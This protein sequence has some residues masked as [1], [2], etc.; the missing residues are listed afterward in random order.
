MRVFQVCADPG[1]APDGT[2]GASVHLRSIATGLRRLGHEVTT[3]TRRPAAD[4]RGEPGLRRLCG[5][6][7]LLAEAAAVGAPDL[8]YERYS[9]GHR[10]GLA[11]ARALGRAFVLEVNA[12]LVDEA[13][14]HRPASVGP[15]DAEIEAHL[16]READLVVAVSNPL[17][18][19]VRAVRGDARPTIV[20]PNGC[21][22]TQEVADPGSAR[23]VLAFL[24]HPKPWHGAERLPGILSR[25][26][27]RGHD[28][29]LL[30]IGGARG[31]EPLEQAA[32]IVG[33]SDRVDVTGEVEHRRVGGL[34]ASAAVGVAPYPRH[35]PF[36]FSPIKVVEYMAAGLPVVTTDQ[37]DVAAL[38]DGA[39][40]VVDPDDIEAFAD[41]VHALLVD[42]AL[43]RRLGR[44]GRERARHLSWDEAARAL[45]EGVVA[46]G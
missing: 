27:D 1:I 6:D 41:A 18:D 31:I 19:I 25:L 40:L 30:V 14:R 46:L 3:F 43:R 24:G 36:Y 35:D 17:A 45:V 28:V 34:L 11:V 32:S 38:V 42:A 16:L 29:S 8:V 10:D 33:V 37:G 4:P 5:T 26:V 21:E 44:T 2:K 15:E 7:S 22:I 13:R 12:P 9:L 23:P 39:G 20:V